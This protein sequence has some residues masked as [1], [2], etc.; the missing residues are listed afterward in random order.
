MRKRQLI[1]NAEMF[2]PKYNTSLTLPLEEKIMVIVEPCGRL[3]VILTRMI[4]D[5]VTGAKPGDK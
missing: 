2:V 5:L 3:R 1:K 4:D